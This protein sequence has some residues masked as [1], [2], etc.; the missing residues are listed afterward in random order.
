MQYFMFRGEIIIFERRC[1]FVSS[2][3]IPTLPFPSIIHHSA[4]PTSIYSVKFVLRWI[5]GLRE[6]LVHRITSRYKEYMWFNYFHHKRHLRERG[7]TLG[8]LRVQ[9]T[10]TQIT[11]ADILMSPKINYKHTSLGICWKKVK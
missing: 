11:E 6:K 7:H 9:A 5:P 3:P 1:L 10:E 4:T 8:G 2:I